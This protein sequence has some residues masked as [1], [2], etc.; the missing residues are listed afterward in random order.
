MTKP[1][2]IRALGKN[3]NDLSMLTKQELVSLAGRF[4]IP[5]PSTTSKEQ[6]ITAIGR[7]KKF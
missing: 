3:G 1:Q 5:G 2:L 7:E 4:D 6:L